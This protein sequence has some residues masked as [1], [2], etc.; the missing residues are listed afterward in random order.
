[1]RRKEQLFDHTTREY[2]IDTNE[3]SDTDAAPSVWE[4][5]S[6]IKKLCYTL[7]L[8]HLQT[9]CT[10]THS[11]ATVCNNDQY[12]TLM[13]DQGSHIGVSSPLRGLRQRCWSCHAGTGMAHLHRASRRISFHSGSELWTIRSIHPSRILLQLLSQQ[14][15]LT[16]R[17]RPL[18]L[19]TAPLS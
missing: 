1:M 15:H 16:R 2:M 14:R 7:L 19:P 9:T 18:S 8:L 10:R 11:A 6:R 12:P 5:L 4:H 13:K 17:A 3:H